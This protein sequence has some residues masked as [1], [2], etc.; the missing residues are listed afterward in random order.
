MLRSR[1]S[2]TRSARTRMLRSRFSMTRGITNRF[3]V[4][5]NKPI[6]CFAPAQHD[7]VRVDTHSITTDSL[8]SHSQTPLD[9]RLPAHRGLPAR[10][11]FPCDC[12]SIQC[13]PL[14]DGTLHV[15]LKQVYQ[16]RQLICSG[17][18]P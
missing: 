12:L 7:T 6:R 16:T 11:R 13:F 14:S 5:T 3:A 10:Q 2:M 9:P 4:E 8:Q 1:F 18:F 17:R 15:Y